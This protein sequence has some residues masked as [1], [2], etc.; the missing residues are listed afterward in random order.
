MLLRRIHRNCLDLHP[1]FS[2]KSKEELPSINLIN[3]V[4]LLRIYRGQSVL[5]LLVGLKREDVKD[6]LEGRLLCAILLNRV[7]ALEV[8]QHAED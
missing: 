6:L 3:S 7:L 8:F 4:I 5:P 1:S 2:S